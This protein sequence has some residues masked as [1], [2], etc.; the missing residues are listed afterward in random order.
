V[1]LVIEAF[2]TNGAAAVL[3]ERVAIKRRRRGLV[4][5]ELVEALFSLWA[6]GGERCEDLAQLR[7]DTA[8]A[9]LLGHDLPAPQTAD[10]FLVLRF[11]RC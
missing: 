3:D 7:E 10:A 11:S 2:R 8:L 5:S 9:M 6:A 1:A 4:P